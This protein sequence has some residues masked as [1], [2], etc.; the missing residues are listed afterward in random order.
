MK[1]GGF[2]LIEVMITVAIVGILA[3]IAIPSYQEY[4]R[5]GQLAEAPSLLADY[6]VR[7]EQSYQDNR[8]YGTG[9]TCA[10]TA[11]A[12]PATQF[13]TYVCAAS[14]SGQNYTITATGVAGSPTAGFAYTLDQANARSTTCTGC[15]WGSL[16]SSAS[17]TWVTKK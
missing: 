16:P 15:A 6:R 8:V 12:A 13:F 1:S 10:V 11:P 17:T 2:T 4:V 9:T 3:T 7:M 5:R 14:N